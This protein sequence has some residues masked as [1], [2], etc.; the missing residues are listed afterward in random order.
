M[1]LPTSVDSGGGALK[2]FVSNSLRGC[3]AGWAVGGL[4]TNVDPYVTAQQVFGFTVSPPEEFG[5]NPDISSAYMVTSSYLE[6]IDVPIL[7]LL[8]SSAALLSTANTRRLLTGTTIKHLAG[9]V[10]FAL[11]I[12]NGYEG[13]PLLPLYLALEGLTVA[14]LVARFQEEE[15]N[16]QL[17]LDS[18]IPEAKEDFFKAIDPT[19]FSS[20]GP[21]EGFFRLGFFSALF[22]GAS[23]AISPVSPIAAVDVGE[24]MASR[25]CCFC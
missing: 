6:L 12:A 17:S 18:V 7:L 20:G 10:V 9:L 21:L 23:F 24:T 14:A 22:V 15:E 25:V 19:R 16:G 5:F 1:R 3:A 4:G 11:G 2:P 13:G 8:A